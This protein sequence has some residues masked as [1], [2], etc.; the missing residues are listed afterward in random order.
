MVSK[1]TYELEVLE[2]CALPCGMFAG[3]GNPYRGGAFGRVARGAAGLSPC[4]QV[5]TGCGGPLK[6]L[7]LVG[8]GVVGPR[9]PASLVPSSLRTKGLADP[10]CSVQLAEAER[11]ELQHYT[12]THPHMAPFKLATAKLHPAVTLRPC[13][14]VTL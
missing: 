9:V 13:G 4:V 8:P 1:V 5:L 10:V 14:P 11:S 7:A 12:Q 3:P 6:K 2:R